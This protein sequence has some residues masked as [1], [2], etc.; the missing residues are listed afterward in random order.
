MLNASVSGRITEVDA[1]RERPFLEVMADLWRYR[2][3]V[4]ALAARDIRVRQVQTVLGAAWILIGP[5]LTVG[6][7]TLVFGLF[8]KVP[9]DGL[10]YILFYLV[11]II[12]WQAFATSLNTSATSIQSGAALMAKIYFPRVAIGV[13]GALTVWADFAV[14]F[15]LIVAVA[16]FYGHLTLQ[17]LVLAPIL[18]LI[19][20]SLALGLGLSLAPL[21]VRY[22]DVRQLVPLLTQIYYFT[23]PVIY[24]ISIVP[25]WI[26]PVY[27]MNPMSVVI[28]GF[29]EALKGEWPQPTELIGA[30]L[31]AGVVLWFGVST[32]VR[33]ERNVVDII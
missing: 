12:P 16:S 6:V 10:P 24:P 9:S 20:T 26:R 15:L 11:A 31:V 32:F 3:L 29:R 19:L 13:A 21:S 14:G 2:D 8:V 28:T 5:L 22:R 30:L 27:A 4:I 7:F 1:R 17:L 33:N 18:L 25:E 23:T